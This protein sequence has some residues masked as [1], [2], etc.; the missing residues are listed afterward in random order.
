MGRKQGGTRER[1]RRRLRTGKFYLQ[2]QRKS[3][4]DNEIRI[5]TQWRK[6]NL[7]FSIINIGSGTSERR[8]KTWRDDDGGGG[9]R[10]LSVGSQWTFRNVQGIHIFAVGVRFECET[11][12]Q[13]T[14]LATSIRSKHIEN[15]MSPPPSFEHRWNEPHQINTANEQRRKNRAKASKYFVNFFV[16]S[17]FH[18][19]SHRLRHFVCVCLLNVH[20]RSCR[21]SRCVDCWQKLKMT[22]MMCWYRWCVFL[23]ICRTKTNRTNRKV[24]GNYSDSYV[25]GHG[26]LASDTT[27]T[28]PTDD[29]QKCDSNGIDMQKA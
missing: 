20:A 18:F 7:H 22:M 12:Q 5:I 29:G 15:M 19:R 23:I 16:P 8:A 10:W 24:A 2:C 1:R 27:R 4:S 13:Y 26:C 6:L 9:W 3:N 28:Q 11:G 21:A 17:V 25:H 14:P